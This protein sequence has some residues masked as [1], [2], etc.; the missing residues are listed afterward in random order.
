MAPKGRL[1]TF[2]KTIT[3]KLRERSYPIHIADG[4]LDQAGE[5]L[6]AVGGATARHAVV[7]SNP[8]IAALYGTR[9]ERRLR[10]S[11]FG[12]DQFLIGDGE[13]F[14]SLK[15]AEALYG[16]LIERRVERSGIIVALG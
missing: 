7:I 15:T 1:N 9:L 12:V 2:V 6:R 3:V 13:R 16:F 11:G 14:K 5:M 8:T 4:G 10:R